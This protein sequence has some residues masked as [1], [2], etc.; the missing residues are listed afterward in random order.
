MSNND[1]DS[2][3]DVMESPLPAECLSDLHF[4]LS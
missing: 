2:C 4:V 1:S 3:V